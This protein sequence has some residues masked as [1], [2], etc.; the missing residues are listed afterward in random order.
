MSVNASV[1]P[2]HVVAFPIAA[3]SHVKPACALLAK[4]V[5]L[6]PVNATLFVPLSLFERTIKELDTQFLLGSE[7]SLRELI[8]VV[9]LESDTVPLCHSLLEAN[10][11][12]GYKTLVAGE[13]IKTHPGSKVV[14]DS[15]K[16]PELVILDF[17]AYDALKGIREVSGK[18]VPIY[19]FESS[20]VAAF[21]FLFGPEEFGGG[22]DL[23][24]K[25]ATISH[26]DEKA[27]S[28]EA[29]R[30]FRRTDGELITIPGIPPMYDYE[31]SP[32]IS[33][34]DRTGAFLCAPVHTFF[35][36][37]DGIVINSTPLFEKP[38]IEVIQKWFDERPVICPGPFNF[39]II[40]NDKDNSPVA[41]EV[42]SF[43]DAA[44]KKHGANSVIYF[45]F[46]SIWWTTEPEKIWAAINALIDL[47][48]PFLFSLATSPSDIP[49]G[50]RTKIESSGLGYMSDWLPQEAILNHEARISKYKHACGWFIS[51]C[52]HNSVM[53]ALCAGVP[54]ICWPF[55]ADQ[56][57]NAANLTITHGLGYELFEIR[58]GHGL[59]PVHRLGDR[60]PEGTV[61]AL[62]REIRDVLTK[63]RGTDGQNKR[64]NVKRFR[65]ELVKNWE[66]DGVC[67]NEIEKLLAVLH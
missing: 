28:D 23:L 1:S 44:L 47:G 64:A 3:W 55:D 43:L 61:D 14:Y 41:L 63:A 34:F 39:P 21:L 57:S 45:S 48:F 2:G 13:P 11:L 51:H 15:I 17:F 36:E 4:V 37:C 53:E 54:L 16:S 33:F 27:A 59:R 58:S 22:G 46:G 25:L 29:D 10:F 52:G 31:Y 18:D 49:E 19:A 40:H 50:L 66:Q 65:E 26:E 9:G 7:N 6:R 56:P 60:T 32:Q 12:E 30:I 24:A 62:E 67:W 8:R 20:A 42:D 38:A 5:R 35:N